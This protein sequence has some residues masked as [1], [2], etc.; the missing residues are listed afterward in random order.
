VGEGGRRQRQGGGQRG[1]SSAHRR[2]VS[3]TG[4]KASP[5]DEAESA[6]YRLVR[7]NQPG[8]ISL[9]G[10]YAL[11]YGAL[12]MAQRDDDGPDW[13]HDL[14]PLDALFPA[15]SGRRSS[16]IPYEFANATEAWLRVMRNTMH[17]QRISLKGHVPMTVTLGIH[18]MLE[19]KPG[20][21]ASWRHSSKPAGN[22]PS[23]GKAPSLGRRSRSVIPAT[24]SST[25]SPSTTRALHTS[26]ARYRGAGPQC[27]PICWPANQTS[28]PSTS[29]LSSH[30]PAGRGPWRPSSTLL[31]GL[32]PLAGAAAVCR[33]LRFVADRGQQPF[34]VFTA[35]AA[36]LQ[37]CRDAGVALCHRFAGV[38]VAL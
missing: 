10:A 31:A 4:G 32:V 33:L 7:A 5:R 21:A 34:E 22:W 3:S 9:A 38:A 23:P 12:G 13:Y 11:G 28:D 29:W 25:R 6:L 19:A 27:R 15:L 37:V 14:D 26:T 8:K 1:R 2:S 20:R 30:R 35:R 17:W 36:R 24:A 18:A 16:V